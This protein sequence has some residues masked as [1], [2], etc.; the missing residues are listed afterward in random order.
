MFTSCAAIS[1]SPT[2]TAALGQH[3]AQREASLTI[4]VIKDIFSYGRLFAAVIGGGV[5]ASRRRSRTKLFPCESS[6]IIGYQNLFEGSV[7]EERNG[8]QTFC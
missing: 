1:L 8:I 2:P 5:V 3:D 6:G 7:Y 4:D